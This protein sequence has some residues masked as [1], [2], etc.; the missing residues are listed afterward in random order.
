MYPFPTDF[1]VQQFNFA[2]L[3]MICFAA[4]SV[5]LH[6]SRELFLTVQ[7]EFEHRAKGSSGSKRSTFPLQN[8][9]LMQLI[10]SRVTEAKVAKDASLSLIFNDG[11]SLHIHTD[12][13]YESYTIKHRGREFFI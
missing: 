11:A 13:T 6:F 1:D 4:N 5:Y 10:G 2:E 7:G 12:E 3:E 9:D 8:S